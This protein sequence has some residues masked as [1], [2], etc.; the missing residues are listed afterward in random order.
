PLTPILN[1]VP[2]L[3]RLGNDD[4]RLCR[5]VDIVQRN[6][7]VMARLIEDLLDVSRITSGKIV[8]RKEVVSFQAVVRNAVDAVNEFVTQKG[9][10]ITI[11]VPDET[12]VL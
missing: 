10:D 12:V 5:V 4:D 1:A 11:S 2:I 6:V 7:E 8:L 3:R 9:H